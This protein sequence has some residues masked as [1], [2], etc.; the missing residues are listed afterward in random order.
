MMVYYSSRP[1]TDKMHIVQILR[2]YMILASFFSDLAINI[3]ELL[4]SVV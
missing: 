1:S 3:F 2:K 4:A